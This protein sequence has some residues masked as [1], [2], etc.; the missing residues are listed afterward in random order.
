MLMKTQHRG[1][2]ILGAWFDAALG[3]VVVKLGKD[4]EWVL[5]VEQAEA[6]RGNLAAACYA[7]SMLP[8][9]DKCGE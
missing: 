4:H 7:S 6:L 3:R 2:E 9:R 8:F 1:I 5:T